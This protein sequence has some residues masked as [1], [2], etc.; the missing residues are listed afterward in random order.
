MNGRT[1]SEFEQRTAHAPGGDSMTDANPL[2]AAGTGVPGGT[3]GYP[4][5]GGYG[6]G[7]GANAV[8]GD[9]EMSIVHYLQMLYRRRYI[10]A[11][12]FLVVVMGTAVYSFTAPRLYQASARILIE[13]DQPNVVSFEEVLQQSTV[14]DDYYETQYQILQSRGLARRTIDSLNLWDAAGFQPEPSRFDI[15]GFLLTPVYMV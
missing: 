14:T 12:A 3:P 2:Q 10:A 11:T 15:R 6:Y 13:R 4:G 5:Y 8:L 1:P 9:S 7:S